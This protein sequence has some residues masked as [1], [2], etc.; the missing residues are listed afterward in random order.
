MNWD[1]IEGDWEQFKDK[2]K[3]KW[4]KLNDDELNVIEG[5]KDR[6]AGKL[7]EKYGI[8]KEEVEKQLHE[9]LNSNEKDKNEDH[10]E[11]GESGERE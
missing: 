4:G 5:K 10:D 9:F 7:Q 1:Q 3:E 8:A 2:V 11:G 6:L